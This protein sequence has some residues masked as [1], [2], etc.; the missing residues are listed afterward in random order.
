MSVLQEK[1]RFLMKIILLTDFVKA[2]FHK[3][4]FLL[5]LHFAYF[6][7]SLIFL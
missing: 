4:L 7:L 2:H 3:D 6:Y 1:K 5:Y